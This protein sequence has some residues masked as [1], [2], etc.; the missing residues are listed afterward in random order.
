MFPF[1]RVSARMSLE[2]RGGTRTNAASWFIPDA[3][4]AMRALAVEA[5]SV[6]GP[7]YASLAID[8]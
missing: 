6:A 7:Q 1:R 4:D 2:V 5:V 8:G 3:A